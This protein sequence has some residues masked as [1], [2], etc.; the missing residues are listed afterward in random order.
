[1]L[2]VIH[3]VADAWDHGNI[4]GAAFFEPSLTIVDDTPPYLFQGRNAVANW[5]KAYR[6][7]QPKGSEGAKASLHFLEPQTVEIKGAR[8]YVAV[9]GEWTVEQNGQSNV[10]HG[11]ITVILDRARQNWR[12]ATW[13]W[14]P[15]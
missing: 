6:D 3:G 9:P 5:I 10:S 8:A 11:I 4:P 13:V 15:R 2:S 7:A 1:M 12:I 14:T